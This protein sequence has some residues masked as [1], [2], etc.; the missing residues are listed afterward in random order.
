MKLYIRA[1]ESKPILDKVT[2]EWVET[3]DGSGITF[4]IYSDSGE[5]V[6]EAVFDYD[7]VDSDAIYDSAIEM[8]MLSLSRQ[9]DLTDSAIKAIKGADND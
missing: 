8:A 4:T 2:T 3:E 6:F 5:V 1:S 7:E 9:Y